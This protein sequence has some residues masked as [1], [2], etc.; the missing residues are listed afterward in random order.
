M[1][2]HN[3]RS[4]RHIIGVKLDVYARMIEQ[5][6]EFE[7]PSDFIDRMLNNVDSLCKQ[8]DNLKAD[9]NNIIEGPKNDT[10]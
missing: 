2:P 5:S 3:R 7:T 9:L 6:D 8:V 4:E 10:N 1:R